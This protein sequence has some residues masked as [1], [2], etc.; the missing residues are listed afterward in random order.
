M[1][2][3]LPFRDSGFLEWTFLPLN[4]AIQDILPRIIHFILKDLFTIIIISYTY[5]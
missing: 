4:N 3:V 1:Q 2:A 5:W